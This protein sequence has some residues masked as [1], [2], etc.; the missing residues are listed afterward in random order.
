[1][2][3]VSSYLH[4]SPLN[5][6]PYLVPFIESCIQVLTGPIT[7]IRTANYWVLVVID[8]LIIGVLFIVTFRGRPEFGMSGFLRFAFPKELFTNP[9]TKTDIKLIF[10]NN[11]IMPFVNVAWRLTAIFFAGILLN[12]MIT[13]FGPPLKIF[14]WNKV[15]LVVFTFLLVFAEDLGFYLCHLAH[16]RIPVLWAFHKLHHSAEVMT[17]LTATRNHP[18]EFMLIP[19]SKALTGSLVLAPALYLFNTMPSTLEVFGMTLASATFA[20]FGSHLNHSHIWLVWGPRMQRM[21]VC[22]AQHQI[23]HSS[24]P[25]HHD[26]NMGGIFS[27][28]DWL[29]GTLY[30]APR[31]PESFALGVYGATRQPHPGLISA[32]TLPFIEAGRACL[33]ALTACRAALR[34]SWLIDRVQARLSRRQTIAASS[35]LPTSSMP[36]S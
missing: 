27:C 14:E 6:I 20:F 31:E 35:S 8:L 25:R 36:T 19:P 34:G 24:A 30:I 16:H 9:S 22:P 12:C 4:N 10:A 1:M 18:V 29:F 33:L 13:V 26:K 17:P 2:Q 11:F 23:H 28:W 3:Q 21:F 15:T 32:Y 5:N 7:G